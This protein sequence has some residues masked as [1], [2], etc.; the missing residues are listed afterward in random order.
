MVTLSKR[1]WSE[2]TAWQLEQGG[3]SPLM[4][5]LYAA[6]GISQADQISTRMED[7]IAP[8]ELKGMATAAQILADAIVEGRKVC[9]VADYDADG[10][11]ACAVA[12]KGLRLLGIQPDKLT[13]FVPDRFKL[14]YGLTPAIVDLVAQAPVGKPDLLI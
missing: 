4:A 7:L 1:A 3:L 11:T 10:A 13:Y 5:R 12:V 9:I 2:R 8:T 6:R 14:G